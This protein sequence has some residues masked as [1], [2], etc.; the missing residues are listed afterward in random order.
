[1]SST[2]LLIIF[3]GRVF[4]PKAFVFQGS[5]KQLTNTFGL[6]VQPL[7]TYQQLSIARQVK[8]AVSIDGILSLYGII[9]IQ[10]CAFISDV[11]HVLSFSLFLKIAMPNDYGYI[12]HFRRSFLTRDS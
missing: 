2:Q 3:N 8:F 10:L 6:N 5:Y 9:S 12:E 4:D 1:M 11:A 7:N